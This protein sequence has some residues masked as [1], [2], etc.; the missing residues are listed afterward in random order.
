[1][2]TRILVVED[3]AASRELLCTWLAMEG[4]QVRQ[5]ATLAEGY[6]E[7]RSNPPD[8]VLLDVQLGADDGLGLAQWIRQQ[9]ALVHIPVIAVTAHAMMAEQARILQSGCNAFIPKPVD[10]VALADSLK[11]WLHAA[12]NPHAT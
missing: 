12:G 11:S 5:A 9:P 7:L 8:V 6:A 10:F 1:M 3:T 4:Y 2:S